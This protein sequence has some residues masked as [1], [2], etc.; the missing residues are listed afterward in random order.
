MP[1][2]ESLA[3]VLDDDAF[4]EASEAWAASVAD[5]VEYLRSKGIDLPADGDLTVTVSSK[6]GGQ[7]EHCWQICVEGICYKRCSKG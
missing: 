6:P 5:P 4:P 1:N 3:A 7:K 2:L